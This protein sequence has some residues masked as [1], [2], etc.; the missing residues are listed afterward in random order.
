MPFLLASI[1][2]WLVLS[3]SAWHFVGHPHNN[4]SFESHN[5]SIGQSFLVS[6][7]RRGCIL[8]GYVAD[9]GS[10]PCNQRASLALLYSASRYLLQ[11]RHC[12][13][14]YTETDQV[15]GWGLARPTGTWFMLTNKSQNEFFRED[16]VGR[17]ISNMFNYFGNKTSRE[18][19]D[20]KR[21]IQMAKKYF[22]ITV[23]PL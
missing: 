21:Y 11:K 6:F 13:D 7:Y 15:C 12:R 1:G 22:K 5:H 10:R 4:S 19:P 8:R 17:I 9:Q 18:M 2:F 14:A 3:A 16:N 23:F 20:P